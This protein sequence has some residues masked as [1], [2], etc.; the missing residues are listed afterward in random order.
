VNGYELALTWRTKSG[1]H[2]P[3]FYGFCQKK[4][5]MYYYWLYADWN[6]IRTRLS[7][8]FWLLMMFSVSRRRLARTVANKES[9]MVL[10]L[11]DWKGRKKPWPS[12]KPFGVGILIIRGFKV[13]NTVFGEDFGFGRKKFSPRTWH[14]KQCSL[15]Q[16]MSGTSSTLIWPVTSVWITHRANYF[17][18]EQSLLRRFLVP[19]YSLPP[20]LYET[21]STMDKMATEDWESQNINDGGANGSSLIATTI[22]HPMLRDLAFS[23]SNKAQNRVLKQAA[24]LKRDA[25]VEGRDRGRKL[26]S[27]SHGLACVRNAPPKDHKDH[28]R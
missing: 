8:L 4:P 20:S 27:L 14:H 22:L 26:A 19:F 5:Q 21:D 6:L 17:D 1:E 12:P 23:A 13:V 2:Q 15:Y 18:V 28:R 16:A 7:M 25:D 3:N 11:V 24:A 10:V 9:L